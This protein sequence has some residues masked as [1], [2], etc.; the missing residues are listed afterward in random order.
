LIEKLKG[1]L[2][3]NEKMMEKLEKEF[4]SASID[5]GISA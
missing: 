1:T 2:K 4:A 3:E 5:S